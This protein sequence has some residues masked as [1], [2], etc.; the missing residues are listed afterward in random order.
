MPG[1]DQQEDIMRILILGGFLGSGKTSVLMD[2]AKYF[3]GDDASNASKVV[4]I[5]NEIGEVGVDDKL[6]GGS[7]LTVQNMFAGCICCSLAGDIVTSIRT[8]R[9]QFSPELVIIESSGVGYPFNIQENLSYSLGLDST[10]ISVVDAS[11][12]KR[13]FIPM[14]MMFQDQLKKTDYLLINKT[15]IA[16]RD[17]I[18]T[19]HEQVKEFCQPRIVYEVSAING[20]DREILSEMMS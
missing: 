20:I 19:V 18:N 7:G 5:E 2:I 10:I 14:H 1:T 6:L 17:A 9:D 13:L 15:D 3:V 4:I 16:D 12:W 11:R 8:I